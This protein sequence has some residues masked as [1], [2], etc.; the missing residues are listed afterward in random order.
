MRA[1]DAGSANGGI[2]LC[3]AN[4]ITQTASTAFIMLARHSDPVFQV[5]TLGNTAAKE[6]NPPWLALSATEP[7]GG[8]NAVAVLREQY[9][10]WRAD[11][12]P[13]CDECIQ[14]YPNVPAGGKPTIASFLVTNA[15]PLVA[16]FVV[17]VMLVT[18]AY[19]VIR[20]R[21]GR[22]VPLTK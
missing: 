6:P 16:A 21:I 9:N 2:P 7:I 13:R 19:L 22:S 18:I 3:N 5:K 20:P 8:R 10:L 14:P 11:N 15:L 12:L 4:G 17:L 1:M